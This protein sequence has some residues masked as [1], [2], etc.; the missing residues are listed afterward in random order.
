MPHGRPVRAAE[1]SAAKGLRLVNGA[2]ELAA[3]VSPPDPLWDTAFTDLLK[4]LDIPADPVTDGAALRFVPWQA[5][6]PVAW[7]QA[8][9]AALPQADWAASY[10]FDHGP[11]SAVRGGPI[12]VMLLSPHPELCRMEASLPSQVVLAAMIRAAAEEGRERITII[13]AST[14]RDAMA[15]MAEEA[16][17]CAAVPIPECE[18]LAIEDALPSLMA[19]R[20]RRDALIVMPELRSIVFALL[21]RTSGLRAPWPIVWH[22]A[23]GP[24]LI[25]SEMLAA[26]AGIIPL[27]AG[28]L[29]QSLAL[30]LRAAGRT[31]DAR[32]LHAAGAGL[33]DR[34][35]VTTARGSQ[36]PY[37]TTRDDAEFV[38]LLCSGAGAG[39]RDAPDWGA[40][41]NKASHGT[42]CDDMRLY[43]IA[44]NEIRTSP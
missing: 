32:R 16:V 12:D 22:A 11:G 14:R 30:A 21:A 4:F 28:V 25:A 17:R 7:Q 38:K 29:V 10:L 18:V 35:V 27:D 43:I 5:V 2:L 13:A 8:A 42:G 37:V 39:G 26:P 1:A 31:R 15:Q 3:P 19:A 20:S 9:A 34:G 24:V 33:R 41:G 36:A 40:I 44:S 6:S 23:A